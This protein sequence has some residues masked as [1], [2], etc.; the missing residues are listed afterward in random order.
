MVSTPGQYLRRVAVVP[1]PAYGFGP[2]TR[3]G[4]GRMVFA[5]GEQFGPRWQTGHELILVHEGAL[6]IET[7]G[8]RLAIRPGQ[9]AL[10][11]PGL[12]CTFQFAST[13]RTVVSYVASYDPD[14]PPPLLAMIDGP[15]LLL[16]ASP[17][18]L[19]LLDLVLALPA[20]P[21]Q[22]AISPGAPIAVAMAALTLFVDEAVAAGVLAVRAARRAEHPAVTASR[23][24]IRQ[25]L[26]EPIGLDEIAAAA[27]VAPEHLI[28]LFRQAF[29]T[30]PMRWLR[31]ERTRL[32]IH[33]LEHT[34][35]P[36]GEIAARVGCQSPKHFARLV[37]AEAGVPPR[38]LRRRTLR[39]LEAGTAQAS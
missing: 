27:H 7:E 4:A 23:A 16:P 19:Q 37:R 21:G 34:D 8:L 20:Q 1:D 29:G 33:L 5:P 10:L 35:L 22:Q 38:E 14:L 3:V 18:M 12:R 9:V 17:A 28:R 26:A 6:A 30:T 11:V 25:H 2:T 36:V 15:P 13:R 24:Y 31:A 32:G 39:L